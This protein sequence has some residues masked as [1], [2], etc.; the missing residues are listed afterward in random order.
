MGLYDWV[1]RNLCT[2]E[3]AAAAERLRQEQDQEL[4][5][6][7]AEAARRA[8]PEKIVRHAASALDRLAAN[9]H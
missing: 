3:I 1:C 6:M 5:E 2:R 7:K 8:D 9:D 4:E